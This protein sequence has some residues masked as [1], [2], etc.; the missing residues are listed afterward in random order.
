MAFDPVTAVFNLVNK[1][2]DKFVPDKMDEKDKEELKQN[3]EMFVAKE[4]RTESSA[5][6]DFVVQYEGAAK[7][8]P[9]LIVILRSLIRPVFTILVGWL[10][11]IY[12]TGHGF[13]PEQGDLLKAVNVIVLFFWF[14]ERA[15]TNSGIVEKLLARK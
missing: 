8:V 10:D 7:D 15:V 12:F 2:L 11:Y 14:G 1:G 13:T 9:R 4:A 3:M 5:F 6:R